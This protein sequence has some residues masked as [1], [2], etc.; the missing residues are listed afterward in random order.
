MTSGLRQGA[1]SASA[2]CGAR[3]AADYEERKRQHLH[4]QATCAAEGLQFVPLVAEACGGGWGP[5][6]ER[7]WKALAQAVAART[8]ETAA[9]EQERLLQALGV[10]LQ[11][12]NARAVL[13]RAGPT[14]V[15][16]PGL[17]DP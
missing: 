16:P 4:T 12:E 1:V 7:A 5:A 2:R 13:R 8:G 17:P 10:A 14:L 11:R 3:A 15:D 6:A 9:V